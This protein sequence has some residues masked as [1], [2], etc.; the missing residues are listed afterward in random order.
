MI[1]YRS[2]AT[3]LVEVLPGNEFAPLLTSR[4]GNN[5][6]VI[7]EDAPINTFV[8]VS[9]FSNSLLQVIITDADYV[10]LLINNLALP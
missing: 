4:T 9:G 10:S 1:G 3:V 6:G 8:R 7:A 5:I 2:Y